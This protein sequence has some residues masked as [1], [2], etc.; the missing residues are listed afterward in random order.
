MKSRIAIHQLL[1]LSGK[2]KENFA[3]MHEA[4]A[5]HA[6]DNVELCIFPEDFLYGVLRSRTDILTAAQHFN[7]WVQIFC[8]LA[9]QY[10]I[11]IV[12]GSFPSSQNGKLYN[13]TLYIDSSGC[14]LTRYSKHSLWLS[15]REEYTP[16]LEMPAVFPT[17]LG[18]T[19]L[20]ICWDIFNPHLFESAVKQ[21]AEWIIVPAFWSVNQS[22]D[23]RQQRGTVTNAYPRYSDSKVLDAL[24]TARSVEF[25]IGILFVNFAGRHEYIGKTGAVQY[26]VSANR[27]QVVTPFGTL[28]RLSNRK[29]TSLTLNLND[30]RSAI[31][32]AEI[33]YGR[34][35][36]IIHSYPTGK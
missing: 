17:R 7:E 36:D 35:A 28:A 13:T 16:S 30:I 1:P 10:K 12:P 8:K 20:L 33:F 5:Q 18:K 26:A 34:R 15:E 24:I 32:D 27:T 6:K 25:N 23:M 14:I 3:T 2:S 31:A 4:V 21:G 11:D 22:E 19:A 29:E 9:I